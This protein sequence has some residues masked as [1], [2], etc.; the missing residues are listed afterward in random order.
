MAETMLKESRIM[1]DNLMSGNARIA[2]TRVRVRDIVE[3]FLALNEPAA[4]IAN[5][6][7]ISVADVYEALSYYYRHREKISEEI[8]KDKEFVERFR[9]E[10]HE[11]SVRREH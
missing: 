5:E 7:R 9:R 3:K 4:V 10:I 1:K 8:K 2:G 6:F 11:V